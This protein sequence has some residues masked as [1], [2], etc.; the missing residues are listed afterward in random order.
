MSCCALLPENWVECKFN[1]DYEIYNNFPYAIRKKTTKKTNTGYI[2]RN[3][4]R[5]FRFGN[6]PV[7]MLLVIAT[8]FIPNPNN[9]KN[10]ELIDKSKPDDYSAQNIRW[11]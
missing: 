2:S 11:I 4:N 10:V 1:T 5:F 3:G 6:K 9:L 8:Q 7:D